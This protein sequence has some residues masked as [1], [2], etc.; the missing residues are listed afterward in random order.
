MYMYTY[1]C[2]KKLYSQKQCLVF[3]RVATNALTTLSF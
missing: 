3:A 2:I 1:L